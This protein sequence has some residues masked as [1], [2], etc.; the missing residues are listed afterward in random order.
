M[1][2]IITGI[3]AIVIC[4]LEMSDAIRD[5]TAVVGREPVRRT[6]NEAI[7]KLAN[8]QLI[9]RSSAVNSGICELRFS[10]ETI[11]RAH[12]RFSRLG[13][14][15]ESAQEIASGAFRLQPENSRG[16]SLSFTEAVPQ[17][18]TCADDSS[19][20]TKLDHLVIAS[21]NIDLTAALLGARLGLSMRAEVRNP[22]WDACLQ[23]FRC[24]DSIIEVYQSLSV[25]QVSDRDSFYGLCWQAN[26]IDL[27]HAR[28]LN[29]E[30]EVSGI[31]VGRK[32]GT[33]VF[34]VRD[35]V[36]GVPTLVVGL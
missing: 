26:N 9:L 29:S 13:M 1:G 23:F 36:I 10:V 30:V 11:A 32:P 7:Y 22:K 35:H 24:G 8:I 6:L 5:I 34:T 18:E 12:K 3:D 33:R 15:D 19:K 17:L 27:T 28:L 16:L 31:R 2:P 14:Y 21:S 4:V 20:I 25:E